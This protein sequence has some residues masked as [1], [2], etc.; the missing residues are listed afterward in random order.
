MTVQPRISAPLL[1]KPTIW[2]SLHLPAS[3]PVTP[4]PL[5][6]LTSSQI[7]KHESSTPQI[8]KTD[9]TQP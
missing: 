6:Y 2:S 5:S 4:T 3:Q 9:W 8:P 7:P 1:P